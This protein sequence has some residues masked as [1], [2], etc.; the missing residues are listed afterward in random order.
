MLLET[1]KRN[2]MIKEQ[3]LYLI[4]RDHPDNYKVFLARLN[5]DKEVKTCS[6]P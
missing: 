6:V 4:K 1:I 2:N 3:I 5:K